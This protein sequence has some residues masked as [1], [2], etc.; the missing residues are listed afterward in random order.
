[1]SSSS[2]IAWPRAEPALDA[3]LRADQD[4]PMTIDATEQ[5]R[6][7]RA[8]EASASEL[9][10]DAIERLERLNQQLNAV[11]NPLFDQSRAAAAGDLPD[12]PFRGVPYLVKD[13]SC[14]MAGVP[15]H[16]GMR[17]VRDAGYVADHDMLMTQRLRRAGLVILGR[18]NAPELGIL[19]TTEPVAYGPTHNPWDLGSSPGG[20]SGGSAAAVAAGIVAAAHANDGGGS[21]R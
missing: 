5:A 11:I 16:E 1:M 2:A 18:T 9:V 19:P 12:G 7:V 4:R 20:S 15:V 6:L 10:E 8:G 3:R 14:Y 21:I 17:A 13:F